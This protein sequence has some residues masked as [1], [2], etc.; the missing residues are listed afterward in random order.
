[1]FCFVLFLSFAWRKNENCERNNLEIYVRF[2]GAIR[3]KKRTKEKTKE[4]KKQERE[5]KK[6]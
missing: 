5:K 6:G 2:E 1:M 4:K 3:K